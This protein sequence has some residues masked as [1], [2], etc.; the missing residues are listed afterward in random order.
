[1]V[2]TEYRRRRNQVRRYF[3]HC[4][5]HVDIAFRSTPDTSFRISVAIYAQIFQTDV[6]SAPHS[7][8]ESPH[9]RK[10]SSWGGRAIVVLIRIWLRIAIY[11]VTLKVCDFPHL[12][13]ALD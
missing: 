4:C 5:L 6:H 9:P 12:S 8:T 2:W 11:H 10:P 1:M 3:N 7:P 13:L